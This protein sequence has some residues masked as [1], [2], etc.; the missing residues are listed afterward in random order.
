MVN[1]LEALMMFCF[2]ISWPMNI[3]KN[4]KARTAKAMSL[5]FYCTLTFGYL[6]GIAAKF[7]ANNINYVL[8]VY[9]INLVM[10]S[11][12]ILIY[13]RNKKI[14]MEEDIKKDAKADLT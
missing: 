14:D 1:F 2:G 4:I 5:G 10:V 6:V 8:V 3:R 11:S 9:I 13:F 12:N 7:I